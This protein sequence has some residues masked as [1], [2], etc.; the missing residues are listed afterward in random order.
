MR[1]RTSVAF[2][3]VLATCNV[4]AQDRTRDRSEGVRDRGAHEILI[5]GKPWDLLGEGYHLTADSTVDDV[6]NV[7][8]TDVSRNR[9]LKIDLEGRINTWREDTNGSHGVAFGPDGRLY[10]GQH[11]RKRIVAFSSDGT[12]SVITEGVQSHHLTVTSRKHIYFTVPPTHTVWLVDAAGHKRTVHDGLNWPRGV[13]ASPDESMLA[14]NDP[15]TRWVW[16]FQIQ[17]D[18]SLANGRP[19]YR[20]ETSGEKS[21]TDAGGMAFDSEGFLYVATNIGVQVCDPQGRAIAV[22]DAPGESAAAVFFGGPGLQWLYVTDGGKV[23]R[24][25]VTRRGAA[26]SRR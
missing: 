24:R 25:P 17:A 22:I 7:Y 15:P 26:P 20:L 13:R 16:T 18:G 11:D 3:A 23:W 12:E 6:G 21:E 5:A 1:R 4:F 10:A 9:I 2:L 19:F 14:V 8:F